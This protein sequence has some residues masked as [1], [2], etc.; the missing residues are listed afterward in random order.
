MNALKGNMKISKVAGTF[1]LP[2]DLLLCDTLVHDEKRGILICTPKRSRVWE[3]IY[4]YIW[5]RK[6]GSVPSVYVLTD[7]LSHQKL[8]FQ[9]RRKELSFTRE[10]ID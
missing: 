10:T 4:I 5:K 1:L 6:T 8:G 7:S 3:A 9:S 2:F